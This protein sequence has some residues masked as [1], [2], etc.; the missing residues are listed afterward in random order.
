MKT[1]SG[2]NSTFTLKKSFEAL[3]RTL[4]LLTTLDEDH[5]KHIVKTY[6]AHTEFINIIDDKYFNCI[7]STHF[8]KIRSITWT[9]LFSGKLQ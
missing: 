7:V 4:D 2:L 1:A 5:L 9:G 8:Q 3:G 6:L